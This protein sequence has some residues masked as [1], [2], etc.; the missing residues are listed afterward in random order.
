MKIRTNNHIK[1][2]LS[3]SGRFVLIIKL[4]LSL[5][6]SLLNIHVHVNFRVIGTK[7]IKF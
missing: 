1:L 4:E 3:E 5:L 2:I 7:R 6:E